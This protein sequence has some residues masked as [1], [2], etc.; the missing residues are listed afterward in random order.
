MKLID[1]R[2]IECSEEV[3]M[4]LGACASSILSQQLLPIACEHL[5]R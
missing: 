1:Q 5:S 3:L 4:A 2:G